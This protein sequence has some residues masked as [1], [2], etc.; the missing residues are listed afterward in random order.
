M[1][2]LAAR[3]KVLLM[4]V[5]AL[6]G[7]VVFGAVNSHPTPTQR[8]A[9]VTPSANKVKRVEKQ[10]Q[11]GLKGT[12]L[13]SGGVMDVFVHVI[14]N[15]SGQGAVSDETIQNQIIVLNEALAPS[16]WSFQL[17]G[18]DTT[19]NNSWYTMTPGTT[20]EAQAKA[21]LHQ[22]GEDTLN[23]YTCNPGQG[24]LGWAT[25]PWDIAQTQGLDGVVVSFT[26]LPGGTR[27]SYNLG[28]TATHEVG[29]WMGLYHTFQGGC[30]GAGDSVSDTPKEK[31]GSFGC[32]VMRNTCSGPGLDPVTNFMDFTDDTCM[33]SFSTGQDTRMDSV[34]TVFR[35]N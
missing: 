9:S 35:L 22:G 31:S 10:L 12:Q 28:D 32:N 11:E 2:R 6:A 27:E 15:S 4:M 29:H 25:F 23:L 8:C 20:A 30:G 16:G 3:A 7:G 13:V 14:K 18:V 1:Y 17:A 19:V 21:T 26:T 5:V 34:L 24:L 33:T